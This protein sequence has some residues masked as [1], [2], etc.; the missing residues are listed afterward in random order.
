MSMARNHIDT[1]YCFRFTV[2]D[3]VA[4]WMMA[5]DLHEQW[6]RRDKRKIRIAPNQPVNT[7]VFEEAEVIEYL[8]HAN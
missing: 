5:S 8:P 2:S 1:D 4:D 6:L 3:E 7:S